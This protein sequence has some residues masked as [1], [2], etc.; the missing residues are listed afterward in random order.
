MLDLDIVQESI[1]I[2]NTRSPL[3]LFG[4]R[5]SGFFQSFGELVCIIECLVNLVQQLGFNIIS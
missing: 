1:F 3:P 5:G 4:D 2:D